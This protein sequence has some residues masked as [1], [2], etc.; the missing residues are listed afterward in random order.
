MQNPKWEMSRTTKN[1]KNKLCSGLKSIRF[2]LLLFLWRFCCYDFL[3]LLLL[4]LRSACYWETS[5]A[6][7]TSVITIEFCA[8][9]STLNIPDWN[10][11][12]CFLG[13]VWFG[14]SFVKSIA[15][16]LLGASSKGP[17]ALLSIP[18]LFPTL[19][20][21]QNPHVG[22]PKCIKILGLQTGNPNYH[23]GFPETLMRS[24]LFFEA[25]VY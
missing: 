25:F 2:L 7:C 24:V 21:P 11:V 3:L 23:H 19:L 17:G 20:S 13:Y 16:P 22:K 9:F 1:K 8:P 4:L 15:R 14:L 5:G 6:T 12:R 18:G 10:R